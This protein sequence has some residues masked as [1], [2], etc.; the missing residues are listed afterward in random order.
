MLQGQALDPGLAGDQH[1]QRDVLRRIRIAIAERG[2]L[3]PV[4]RC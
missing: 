3:P 1:I 2:H 4:S